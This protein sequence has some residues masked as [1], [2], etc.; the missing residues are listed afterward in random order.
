MTETIRFVFV[1]NYLNHHQIPFCDAMYER[2]QGSFV[3]LQT[4][5][6][7]QERIAMGWNAE[8]EKPYLRM[9]Q[10][11][12][13]RSRQ[14]ILDAE[15]VLFGGTDDETY[16]EKRLEEKK[17]VV[18]YSERL[19]KEGQWKC[20]SPRGLM[21]KYHDHTRHGKDPVILLCS[22]AYVPSDF[23]IVRAYPNKMYVWGY[24]PETKTYDI[25]ALME[26]KA[27]N[28]VPKILW[29]ARMID[30]KH[31]ELPIK[32]AAELRG[33][34][35]KFHL[36]VVGGGEMMPVVEEL[37]KQYELQEYVTL[38]GFKKPAE[39]R[40]LMEQSNIYLM[41]SDRGEGWGA[42]VNEAMNSGCAVVGNHMVG[43]VPYL[44]EHEKCGMIY[45]DK[46][47]Q[48]LFDIVA[49]LVEN[50][51]FTRQLGETAYGRITGLW[52]AENAA[53]RLLK[54]CLKLGFLQPQSC[55]VTEGDA[56]WSEGPC[57]P[58]KVIGERKM[59]SYLMKKN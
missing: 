6:V 54:L 19:Y 45:R 21:K 2:L 27:A 44:L 51:A 5:E 58:A 4:E 46:E 47:D 18:R 28:A 9:F 39:V 29:A 20:V 23:S 7:E 3:F 56:A 16:I 12:P 34:G 36:D 37:V 22:G 50:Q 14:L 24:F 35:L 15:V 10:E 38:H 55:E 42:V 48:A 57:S 26:K 25:K 13:E 1:S 52:N 17:P 59:F 40:E 33:R 49:R 43:A 8:N 11:D 53:D 31:P 30:W 41:T 32:V